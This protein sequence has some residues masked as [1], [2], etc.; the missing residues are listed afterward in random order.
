MKYESLIQCDVLRDGGSYFVRVQ[1]AGGEACDLLLCVLMDKVQ[2]TGYKPLVRKSQFN[3]DDHI[4]TYEWHSAQDLF[5]VLSAL[6][7]QEI[8][9]NESRFQEMKYLIDT[10]GKHTNF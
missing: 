2:R 7:R 6:P 9:F 10:E 5:E 8:E 1:D 3:D 4:E